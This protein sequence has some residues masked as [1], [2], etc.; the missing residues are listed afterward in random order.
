[1]TPT[2]RRAA[3]Q[4]LAIRAAIGRPTVFAPRMGEP[5]MSPFVR[6]AL[7]NALPAKEYGR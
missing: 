1:M 2:E 5:V 4:D 3:R 7:R 6:N